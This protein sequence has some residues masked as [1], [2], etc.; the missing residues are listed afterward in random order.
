M[1]TISIASLHRHT[2][3]YMHSQEYAISK[4]K[5][6]KR[7][8]SHKIVPNSISLNVGSDHTDNNNAPTVEMAN[9]LLCLC[10]WPPHCFDNLHMHMHALTI[11]KFYHTEYILQIHKEIRNTH[12]VHIM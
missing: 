2:V 6:V 7:N 10:Q 8:G 1:Q 4:C 9:L 3:K 5:G 12:A 11:G